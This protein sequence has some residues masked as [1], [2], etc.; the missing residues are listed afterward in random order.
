MDY[1]FYLNIIKVLTIGDFY[2]NYSIDL[3]D[4]P[5]QSFVIIGILSV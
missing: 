3:I 1:L 2:I 5:R 4:Y